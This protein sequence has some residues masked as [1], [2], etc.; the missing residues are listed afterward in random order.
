MDEDAGPGRA[1]Q[2][3]LDARARRRGGPRRQGRRDDLGR[4]HRRHDGV[5]AAADGPDQ[6]RQP[7]GDRHHRSRCPAARPTVLLDAGANAEVQ[8]EWLVQFAQMGSV[9]SQH[10][11]GVADPK[12]GLLSIG[13][14]PGK[15][16][17]LRKEAYEL[18]A[19]APGINF[20][21]NVEGRDMMTEDGRRHRHRRLHRQRRAEDARGRPA[22]GRSRALL[23]AFGVDAGVQAARRRADAGAAA[24]V[25]A[26]RPRDLRRGDAARRR[27]GVHHLPRLV[28][29]AAIVNA[30]R[31]PTRWSRAMWW[32]RSVAPPSA[33][34]APH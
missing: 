5:G 8:P 18:L 14:E 27:R 31:S 21:G 34:P 15:G 4:Q 26:A 3:G 16:D 1:P 25:R 12:V 22:S 23:K 9:Y 28:E 11:F 6:G 33:T 10:R 32:E 19:A 29:R 17:T 20:I 24:A 30:I 13:E 2:E 7:S